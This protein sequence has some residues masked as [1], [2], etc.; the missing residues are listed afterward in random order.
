MSA[1]ALSLAYLR[2]QPLVSLLTV[3]LLAAGVATLTLLLLAGQQLHSRLLRDAQGW[4]LVVGAKG[5]PLQLVLA[6]VYHLDAPTGN[7]PLDAAEAWARHPLVAD[8]IPLALGDSYRGFRIVGTRP[9]YAA[10]YQARLAQGRGWRQPMEAVL[11]ATVAQRSG[12]GVGDTL[13]GAHGLTATG[14]D[15]AHAPY[16]V[17]GVFAPTHSVI[18][19][20]VLTGVES[21]WQLHAPATAA[22][23]DAHA[24]HAHAEA[25]ES[26]ASREITALLLR[27]KTPRAAATLPRQI[28]AASALQAASPAVEVTRLFRLLGLGFDV[29]RGFAV[30]LLVGALLGLFMALSQALAQRRYD[31]ALLRTLG[32]SPGWLFGQICLQALLLAAAG[33]VLGIGL[34]HAAAEW[35]G[36]QLSAGQ[37]ALTG[38][39]WAPGE[40]VLALCV[41]VTALAAALP[42]AW[43]A[44]RTDIAAVL[45]R[46]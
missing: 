42:P 16:R 32:A 31:L 30:L 29:L 44:Y 4:D 35:V 33:W 20:L 39:L 22:T 34:G 9:E 26:S 28:N 25:H 41:M 2:A 18:D 43:R 12:L 10:H 8:A 1:L 17:V 7:I 27:Y 3:L 45:A 36:R 15:H 21:V 19:R 24:Q 14:A 5:S 23:Q 37:L 38:L 46:G 6:A 40:S 13:V 11:G